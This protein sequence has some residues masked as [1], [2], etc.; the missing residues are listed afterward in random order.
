[1]TNNDNKS[2]LTLLCSDK[3]LFDAEKRVADFV[4]SHTEEA[5]NMTLSILAKRSG[6]SEAT[7]SRFC[8]RLGFSNY[9]SFQF[10]LA[11]DLVERTE[12]VPVTDTVSL[13][14]IEQSLQNILATKA[15]EL[16]ATINQL[17]AAVLKSVVDKLCSA[18]VIEIAAVGNTIP[19]AM[20]TAF[21]FN[22]LGLRCTTSEI[23]EK[24][25]AY[26]LT[27]TP[28]DVLFVISNS[29]KSKRLYRIVKATREQGSTVIM[30]TSNAKSPIGQLADLVLTSI[31]HE[32]LLTTGDFP[33]S[34]IP[35]I[36][37]VEVIY[38]FLLATLPD[39][40]DSIS[41]HEEYMQIDKSVD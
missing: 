18:E 25:S 9:R 22:Q 28:R 7:V 37:V 11:R 13:D 17:D 40:R 15:S 16:A 10:S 27:L 35:T 39:A 2:A 12:K 5:T 14:D 34:K 24:L 36:A 8:K 6:A 29:G 38:H 30:L 33:F 26:A 41:R 3:V 20:D 1:M 32:R 31:S 4:L 23:H 21:K 19:V